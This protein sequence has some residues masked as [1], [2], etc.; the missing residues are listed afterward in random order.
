MTEEAILETRPRAENRGARP[1]GCGQTVGIFVK[2][3]DVIGQ[4]RNY[5]WI[6][7]VA[8]ANNS[9]R[10]ETEAGGL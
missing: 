1:F 4:S 2:E 5:T 6:D 8:H 10:L 9:N 3:N 7:K